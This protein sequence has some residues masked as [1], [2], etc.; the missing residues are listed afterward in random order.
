[1]ILRAGMK[2]AG[3]NPQAWQAIFDSNILAQMREQQQ[4]ETPDKKFTDKVEKNTR[5]DSKEERS[6]KSKYSERITHSGIGTSP[7]I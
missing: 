2:V 6:A 5:P 7:H 3:N 4:D 1:M